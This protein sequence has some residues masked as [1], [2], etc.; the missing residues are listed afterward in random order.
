MVLDKPSDGVNSDAT[1]APGLGG[2]P[3]QHSAF[4]DGSFR[5]GLKPWQKLRPSIEILCNNQASGL[6]YFVCLF[7]SYVGFNF[8]ENLGYLEVRIASNSMLTGFHFCI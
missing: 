8:I 7:I 6:S 5:S 1:F 3:L 2:G 4:G